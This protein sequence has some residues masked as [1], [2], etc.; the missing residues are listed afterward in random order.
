[1][2]FQENLFASIDNEAD[3]SDESN[4]ELEWETEEEEDV[5]KNA[6]RD[7][8]PNTRKMKNEVQKSIN[9]PSAEA[10][11]LKTS[12]QEYVDDDFDTSD[13]EVSRN[14]IASFI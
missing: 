4:E 8:M 13:E 6:S 12:Y 9:E 2:K 10:E 3:S 7:S 1:V 5:D 14:R 11:T